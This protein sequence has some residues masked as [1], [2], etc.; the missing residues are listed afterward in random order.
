MAKPHATR[1]QA[2]P[3]AKCGAQLKR[4]KG[5]CT[6]AAGWRTDHPGQ[7][8]CYL[9][10]GATP[11]KHGR[12]SAIKREGLQERI[13]RFR[14]DP[15]PL[16][17]ADEV[18]LLR[19]F[20]EDFIDRWDAIYGPDGALI[21]WHES[22]NTNSENPAPKPR[23][24]PDFA[25]L[26]VLVD[27]VGKMVERVHK[28][29]NEGAITLLTLNRIIEQMGADLVAAIQEIELDQAQGSKLLDAVESRWNSIRLDARA[30]GDSRNSAG[31]AG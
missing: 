5:R 2:K 12:Y 18:A 28:M 22:F 19:A 11:I 4:G 25:T 1:K 30:G 16:N 7:G 27:R 10:G 23:Q 31:A 20:L 8:R 13:D 17:L 3:H 9:H 21:A 14:A 29:R 6:K 26:T 15:D 24:M